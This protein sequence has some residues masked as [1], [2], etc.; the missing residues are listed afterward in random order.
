MRAAQVWDL[1]EDGQWHATASWKAH[2][3]GVCKVAWAHPEFGQVIASCSFDRTVHIWEEQ[4][5]E[6][7]AADSAGR[8]SS[9]TT[10]WVRKAR[11][12]DSRDAVKDIKFAPKHLGLRLATCS[13]DGQVRIYEAMDVMNLASWPMVEDFEARRGPNGCNCI[14]WGPNRDHAPMLA[15]G[16]DDHDVKVR[17]APRRG[18]RVRFGRRCRHSLSFRRGSRRLS[19]AA[20]GVADLGVQRSTAPLDVHPDAHRTHGCR[21][22]RCVCA[23]SRPLLSAT[24][25][26]VARRDRA[27]L[28]ALHAASTGRLVDNAGCDGGNVLVGLARSQRRGL[29]RRVERYRHNP[30]HIRRRWSWP[31]VEGGPHGHLAPRLGVARPL[32]VVSAGRGPAAG[33]AYCDPPHV[34]P[35]RHLRGN[36]PASDR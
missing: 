20:A 30:R 23:Q 2:S 13:A 24:G 1:G 7:D 5:A 17:T 21:A 36:Q 33:G 35:T 28:E 16:S 26:S 8:A 22:R 3:A 15:V 19:D 4:L 29:G 18:A 34:Q 25:N 31:V 32:L 10:T 14:S 11:L 12:V 6:S 27:H 9:S